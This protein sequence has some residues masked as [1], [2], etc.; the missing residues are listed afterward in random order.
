MSEESNNV[1]VAALVRRLGGVVELTADELA[2]AGPYA[3]YDRA[4]DVIEIRTTGVEIHAID[5]GIVRFG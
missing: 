3:C 4:D 1:I 5:G 2:A